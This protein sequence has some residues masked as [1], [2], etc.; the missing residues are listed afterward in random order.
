MEDPERMAVPWLWRDPAGLERSM[1]RPRAGGGCTDSDPDSAGFPRPV[2]TSSVRASD[3]EHGPVLTRPQASQS[4]VGGS[5]R[6]CFSSGGRQGALCSATGGRRDAAGAG[7]GGQSRAPH[8]D[9]PPAPPK[10][11]SRVPKTDL[12]SNPMSLLWRLHSAPALGDTTE[13]SWCQKP[14]ETS[15]QLRRNGDIR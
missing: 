10:G 7:G 5:R 2:H 8:G 4:R 13:S 15:V 12:L 3:R 6:T 14:S 1:S 11:L 9:R